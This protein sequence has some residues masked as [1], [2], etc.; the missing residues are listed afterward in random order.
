MDPVSGYSKSKLLVKEQVSLKIKIK[1]GYVSLLPFLLSQFSTLINLQGS[2][3]CS[4]KASKI[5][6]FSIPSSDIS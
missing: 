2:F 3:Q 1:F 6:V 4:V 5:F